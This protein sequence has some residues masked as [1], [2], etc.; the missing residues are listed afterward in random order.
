MTPNSTPRD[1]LAWERDCPKAIT[2]D[3]IWKLVAY[4][5]AFFL[6]DLARKDAGEAAKR[7]LSPELTTQ[8]L[9]AVA[10]ISA[11]LAEGYS[12]S[13]RADRLRFYGYAL[14]SVRECPSWYRAVQDA[15]SADICTHRLDVLARTRA[16]LLGLIRSTRTPNSPRTDFE[17]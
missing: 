11:N 2:S 1:Q 7:G 16:L 14:G 15:L 9:R 12:R 17:P 10:S 13:T 3:P 5:T 8:L 6:L 4:R